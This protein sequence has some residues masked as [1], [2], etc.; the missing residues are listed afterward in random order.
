MLPRAIRR[1]A[2]DVLFYADH[3]L[4]RQFT[5]NELRKWF[6][7]LNEWKL[8]F[9]MEG[10]VIRP[11]RLVRR[12]VL[13]CRKAELRLDSATRREDPTFADYRL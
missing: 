10:G 13:Q 1:L 5:D 7:L 8:G 11:S 9:A 3:N 4:K 12:G 2:I 6:G